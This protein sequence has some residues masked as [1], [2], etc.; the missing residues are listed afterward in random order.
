M[1]ITSLHQAYATGKST[2]ASIVA[3]IY[4]RIEAEGLHP[5]WISLVPAEAALKRAAELEALSPDERAKL[6]LFGIP[7]AIKDNI[8]AANLPTTVGCPAYAFTPTESATVLTRLE[9]AGAILIGKTNMDQFATGLVGT[10]SPYGICSSVFNPAYISG[11]SSA[12]SAVAVASGLVTFALGTD[13]AGSGRVPAMF[14]NLIG[15]KPTRGVLS[16]KGVFPACRTLDCVSI[17]AE[18]SLDASLVLAAAS[19][20]DAED[21]YSR[22]PAI[23]AQATPWSAATTFRF[24][25]PAASTL[26]FFGDTHNPTLFQSAVE[27]LVSL[28]GEPVEID[29][30]PFLAA[31]QLLYKGPWVAERYANIAP[32]IQHHADEMDPTVATIISGATNYSAVD[33]FNAA[34]KLDELRAKTKPVWQTIDLLVLPT[35][36]RT[37]TLAEI[38]ANPIELN[39]NLGTYTNFVNLLDLS[40]IAVPTGL[41]PDSLPFGVSLIAPAFHD[42]GL[43]TL[44]DRLHRATTTTLGGSPRK[45]AETKPLPAAVPPAGTLL[46]AVVGAHL[47]GQPLNWQL[48]QRGGRLLCTCRTHPDYKFYALKGTVPPKPGLVHIP[49]YEGP[50]IEVEIWALPEDTVGSFVEGVPP[51]LCIGTLR[52]ED[53]SQ[54]KGFLAEPF[55]IENATEI[56]HFGGWRNYLQSLK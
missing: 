25:V 49:N 10:R 42:A 9:A 17:F 21:P 3:E 39:T 20:F 24:G 32:F 40:A 23:G 55:G 34:Y 5:I 51:P 27:K 11:G 48:T 8:D 37:Y 31:A 4:A 28:G 18:T 38:A 30:A 12:G 15:L 44:A 14:N 6:P 43:L 29:L 33:T 22:V 26:N 56:T 36:P 41:R 35:A 52:L 54:V 1:D 7:F 2:I 19:S 16:T 53:G 50:G 45:L 47:S 46:M 13:T